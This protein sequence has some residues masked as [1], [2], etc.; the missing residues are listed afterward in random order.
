MEA[1]KRGRQ[2]DIQPRA[3]L[4]QNLAL[5]V[6][7]SATDA[8]FNDERDDR[9]K[10]LIRYGLAHACTPAVYHSGCAVSREKEARS[11]DAH[12]LDV[13]V[14]LPPSNSMN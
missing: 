4:P 2:R 1:G 14:S 6:T 8:C 13:P 10:H 5:C 7:W 12:P 9:A 3:N 11:H